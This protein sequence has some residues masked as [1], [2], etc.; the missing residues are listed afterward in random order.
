MVGGAAGEGRRVREL[1]LPG[2]GAQG[3]VRGGL[4]QMSAS[5]TSLSSAHPWFD[6]QLET[7]SSHDVRRAGAAVSKLGIC[8]ASVTGGCGR[9]GDAVH[10]VTAS[11]RQDNRYRAPRSTRGLDGGRSRPLRP[12]T[13][14]YGSQLCV[15]TV[16]FSSRP[17]DLKQPSREAVDTV[18]P[19]APRVC[20]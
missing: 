1:V 7:D 16:A 5:A 2:G 3:S 6:H 4:F 17:G 18:E 13:N 15:A 9:D 19:S 11:S 14:R 20:A 10:R 8:H 12:H